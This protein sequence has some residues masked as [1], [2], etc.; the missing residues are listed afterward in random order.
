MP[1]LMIILHDQTPSG[2]NQQKERWSTNRTGKKIRVRYA[3]PLFAAWRRKAAYE[4][5]VQKRTWPVETRMALPLRGTLAMR[6]RYCAKDRI[7]RDAT[8]IED[9]IQHLLEYMEIIEDDGQIR[10]KSFMVVE[11]EPCAV[12]T[13]EEAP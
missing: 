1:S 10:D 8:G 6:V 4:V 13:L 2:K 9:A 12:V 3:N 7:R 5:L 11:Q